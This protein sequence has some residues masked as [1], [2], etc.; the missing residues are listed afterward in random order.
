MKKEIAAAGAFRLLAPRPV[1][2]LTTSY[3]GQVNVMS[4]GWSSAVSEEPPLIMMAIHPSRYTHGMLQRS[5]E[6]VLN[7]PGRP[8]AEQV[9]TCGTT[10]GEDVDKLEL[11]GLTTESAQGVDAPWIDECLA[12]IE[13]AIVDILTPGD[14]SLFIAQVVE[15]WV[16]EEAFKE[17]WLVPDNEELLPLQHLGGKTFALMG[18]RITLP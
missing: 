10:S 14:H 2:L 13:C 3:K 15:V 4:F 18:E 12:H 1:C 8:L 5:E 7:I 11:T 6:C 16:E 9:W 17:V